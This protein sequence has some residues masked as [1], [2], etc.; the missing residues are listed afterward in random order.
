MQ[1]ALPP[2]RLKLAAISGGFIPRI[3]QYQFFTEE[4]HRRTGGP[5]RLLTGVAS[6]IRLSIA[7]HSFVARSLVSVGVLVFAGRKLH[8]RP[9]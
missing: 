7:I 8:P 3:H 4:R 6:P 1:P 2:M 9:G 5:R